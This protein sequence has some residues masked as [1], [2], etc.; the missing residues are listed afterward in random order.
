MAKKTK[1]TIKKVGKTKEKAVKKRKIVLWRWIVILIPLL[2]GIM[3]LVSLLL[4]KE[5]IPIVYEQASPSSV[6]SLLSLIGVFIVSY[7]TFVVIEFRKDI[8]GE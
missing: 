3:W 6:Q 1:K 7:G 8:R 2:V 4:V 5:E